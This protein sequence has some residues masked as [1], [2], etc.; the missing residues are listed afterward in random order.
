MSEV[1]VKRRTPGGRI[2]VHKRKR[3]PKI[4][5]CAICKKPLHGVPRLRPS[6]LRN[7]AKSKRRPERMFGGYL[8]SKCMR[9]TLKEKARKEF[10]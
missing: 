1:K 2:A 4:A 5:R 7:I 10:G 6:K 8:C 9:E 3:K